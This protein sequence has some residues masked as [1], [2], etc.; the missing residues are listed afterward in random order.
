MA[1]DVETLEE[2]QRRVQA[3]VDAVPGHGW[4]RLT[5]LKPL[6]TVFDV[7]FQ[8]LDNTLR[9]DAR[10][11]RT[12]ENENGGWQ[13]QLPNDVYEKAFERFQTGYLKSKNIGKD[14]KSHLEKVISLLANWEKRQRT[15]DWEDGNQATRLLNAA[16]RDSQIRV[17]GYKD[18]LFEHNGVFVRFGFK[19]TETQSTRKLGGLSVERIDETWGIRIPS[20]KTGEQAKHKADVMSIIQLAKAAKEPNL[21]FAWLKKK[22]NGLTARSGVIEIDTNQSPDG[23]YDLLLS[24]ANGHKLSNLHARLPVNDEMRHQNLLSGKHGVTLPPGTDA[25]WLSQSANV[26]LEGVPGTGKTHA[27]N[28]LTVAYDRDAKPVPGRGIRELRSAT[29]RSLPAA[30]E[31]QFVPVEVRFMTM[32]PSTSYED[33]VEGL[34][35]AGNW[36]N[37]TATQA[38]ADGKS[39]DPLPGPW[40]HETT[41]ATKTKTTFALKNGFFVEACVAAVA[42][43]DSAVVVVLDEL[44]RCNIPKVLGDLMTVIEE[45]KRARWD[46]DAW[47]VDNDTKAVTLPYS[48]RKLFVPDNLFIVGTMN[49]TD[50][51]VAPMDAALRRRFSFHRIWPQGYG[52]DAASTANGLA[53]RLGNGPE[54]TASLALWRSINDLLLSRYGADAMLGHSYLDDL[55]RALT[56]TDVKADEVVAYHW[57]HRILPQLMDVIASNGLTRSLVNDPKAFFDQNPKAKAGTGTLASPATVFNGRIDVAFSGTGSQRMAHLTFLKLEP[58]P[59]SKQ[60][61]NGPKTPDE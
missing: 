33:F 21:G 48:G 60:S 43:P 54:I 28:A 26:I 12:S 31:T 23:I 41:A 52:P 42:N 15:P 1:T 46:R 45:S 19:G 37:T 58:D 22:D 29:G 18:F 35:P 36:K 55:S 17:D 20:R 30:A 4:E 51:S 34:R 61:T 39:T 50:R 59:P 38:V 40:F 13:V 47:V 44:N 7:Q 8:W 3:E 5:K 6:N 56:R 27:I 53:D 49:T 10:G 9:S 11:R 2:R 57:N 14:G 32:H 24:R 25:H 16:R